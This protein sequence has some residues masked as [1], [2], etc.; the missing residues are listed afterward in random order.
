MKDFAVPMLLPQ[1]L[2]IGCPLQRTNKK[3]QLY[4]RIA[5]FHSL[6]LCGESYT[7][8]LV[9]WLKLDNGGAVIVANPECHRRG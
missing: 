6:D 8:S 3:R 5:I 7:Q 4:E 9:E 1:P 2:P